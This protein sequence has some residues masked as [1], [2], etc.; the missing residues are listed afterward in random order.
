M[1][2]RLLPAALIVIATGLGACSPKPGGA[3][4]GGTTSM[5]ETKDACG[6][7]GFQQYVG[8]SIGALNEVDLPDGARVLFP[9]TPATMDLREDRLN[10]EVGKDDHIVR[11]FC[12]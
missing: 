9:T 8:R 6:A 7:G 1:T 12:G 5:G 2:A 4:A 10:V 11:I 3:P